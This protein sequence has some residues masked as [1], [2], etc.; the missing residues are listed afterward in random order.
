M[1]LEND[2]QHASQLCR[3]AKLRLAGRV[4]QLSDED[5]AS[6]SLLPGW[7]VGHIL[8]HL[9][10]N[11]DGHARRLSGAL[12]AKTFRNML[13]VRISAGRKLS[14]D[15]R[16]A[17][18]IIEDL[19]SSMVQLEEVFERC[20]AAGW[21]NGQLLGGGHYGASECPAHRLRSGNAPRGSRDG[22]HALGLAG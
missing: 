9:A 19:K 12:E 2:P 21:P 3:E 22:L 11:A 4:A 7:S 15:L 14:L 20:T 1:N 8:T 17:A 18:E 5:I 16:P 13:A 10:R 6:P